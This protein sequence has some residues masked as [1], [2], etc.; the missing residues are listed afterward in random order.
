MLTCHFQSPPHGIFPSLWVSEKVDHQKKWNFDSRDV[1]SQIAGGPAQMWQY[2][3]GTTDNSYRNF[4]ASVQLSQL[5]VIL[6]FLL[7][8]PDKENL[9]VKWNDN[10]DL[11]TSI[12]Q[13]QHHQ[14][15]STWFI[16]MD[17]NQWTRNIPSDNI[18]IMRFGKLLHRN[19]AEHQTIWYP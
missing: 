18:L 7:L 10:I 8:I 6:H 16:S 1:K 19:L 3:K 14:T 5:N 13:Q 17:H 12:P 9:K 15:A 4:P 2:T 11:M